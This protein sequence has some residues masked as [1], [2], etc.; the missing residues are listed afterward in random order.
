MAKRGKNR[1]K[2][3]AIAALL[4]GGSVLQLGSCDP[5]VRST[6]LTGLEATASTLTQTFITAYFTGLQ[7]DVDG[8]TSGLTTTP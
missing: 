7:E 1:M 8:G 6:L 3:K 4:V 2:R 5:T